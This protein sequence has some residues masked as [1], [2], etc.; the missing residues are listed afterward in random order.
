H[1]HGYTTWYAHLSKITSWVGERVVGGTPIGYVGSTGYSTGPHLHFETRHYDTPFNPIPRL[2]PTATLASAGGRSNT[3][4]GEATAA[5][6]E[7][8]ATRKRRTARDRCA[9]AQRSA[10]RPPT[11]S[12]W[13]ARESLCRP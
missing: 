9:Q 5:R 12:D 6:D 4:R 10:R 7:R 13:I 11:G 1:R 2:L 3:S 8:S